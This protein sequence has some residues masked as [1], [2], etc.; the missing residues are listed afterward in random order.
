MSSVSFKRLLLNEMPQ[1]FDVGQVSDTSDPELT[2]EYK[3]DYDYIGVVDWRDNSVDVYYKMKNNRGEYV[4]MI[5]D[6]TVAEYSFEDK[7]EYIETD[8]FWQ[9][10][11]YRGL[12][13]YLFIEYILPRHEII[14]GNEKLSHHGLNFWKK[15]FE[16]YKDTYQIGVLNVFTGE[17]KDIDT[18]DEL[19]QYASDLEESK[20][21]RIFIIK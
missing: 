5:N 9:D 13:K 16:E 11:R 4:F 21:W 3:Q 17:Q 2:R 14:V 8:V 10:K 18:V 6:E 7:G 1:L 19:I 12:F 20:N 15:I